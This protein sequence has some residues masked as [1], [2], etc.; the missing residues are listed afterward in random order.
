M[1]RGVRLSPV[2]EI[3]GKLWMKSSRVDE[4]LSINSGKKKE[5]RSLGRKR[6]SVRIRTRI[7]QKERE[8]ERE[9]YVKVGAKEKAI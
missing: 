7:R 4:T 8:G 5:Q 6:R 2:A 1:Q 3:R 9:S